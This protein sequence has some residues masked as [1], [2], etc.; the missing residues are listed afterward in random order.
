MLAGCRR[1]RSIRRGSSMLAMTTTVPLARWQCTHD[2]RL[3]QWRG[4]LTNLLRR[5]CCV[6]GHIG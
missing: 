3:W 6:F 2:R 5:G 4:V 1:L